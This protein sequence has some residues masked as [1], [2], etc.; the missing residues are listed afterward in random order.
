MITPPP[1]NSE[2]KITAMRREEGKPR[3]RQRKGRAGRH[4]LTP[5]RLYVIREGKIAPNDG[6][7]R[8]ALWIPPKSVKVT[9][10]KVPGTF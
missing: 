10:P 3:R 5:E 4:P 9:I 7:D 2:L 6:P 8:A 1:R